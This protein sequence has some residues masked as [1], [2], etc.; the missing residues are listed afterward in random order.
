MS[1]I[2]TDMVQE[3]FS[4]VVFDHHPDMQPPLFDG[5]LS[6]GGWVAGVLD[7]NPMLDKVLLAGISPSLAG[8]TLPW[9]DRVLALDEGSFTLDG[10]RE[11]LGFL[12]RSLPVYLSIDKDVLGRQWART[13]WDQGSLS[14]PLLEKAIEAL[15]ARF[16]VIG[17][18]IC[19]LDPESA[20]PDVL[21]VNS[22]TDREL[23]SFLR[24]I[25]SV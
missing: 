13:N 17:A 12:D 25:L 14:L 21:E 22:R 7:G 23:A 10:F 2:W 5:V 6:C 19:G 20:D 24:G 16:R 9:K 1:K 15:A 18:D 8:E 11:A 4:L 3:P